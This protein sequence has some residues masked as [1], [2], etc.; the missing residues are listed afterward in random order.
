MAADTIQQIHRWGVFSTQ[1]VAKDGFKFDGQN[2][3]KCAHS[4]SAG[5]NWCYH[6]HRGCQFGFGVVSFF[7]V[8]FMLETHFC[9]CSA[10]DCPHGWAAVSTAPRTLIALILMEKKIIDTLSFEETRLWV[11]NRVKNIIQVASKV[12]DEGRRRAYPAN[13]Q[14]HKSTGRRG[15]ERFFSLKVAKPR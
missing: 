3:V 5:A 11:R 4:W 9:C 13:E 6:G 7:I 10:L 1:R 8:R 15:E 12:M 2:S 14:E